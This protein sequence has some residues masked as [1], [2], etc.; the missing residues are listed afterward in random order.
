MTKTL[1]HVVLLFAALNC[2]GCHNPVA[3]QNYGAL[4]VRVADQAGAPIRDVPVEVR[5]FPNPVALTAIGQHTGSDGVA[6]FLATIP[7]GNHRVVISVPDGFASG[8]DGLVQQVKIVKGQSVTVGF[9][10]IHQ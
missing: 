2:V 8:A 3:P 9:A 5:D 1:S 6:N 10:L 7:V 4:I